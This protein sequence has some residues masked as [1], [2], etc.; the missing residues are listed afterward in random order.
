VTRSLLEELGDKY[1]CTKMLHTYLPVLHHH[2]EAR[3]LAVKQVIEIGVQTERSVCM[4]ADYFPN[5]IIYGVDIDEECKRFES[6]RVKILI[7]DQGDAA[8][9]RSLPGDVDIIIDDGSHIPK[10]VMLGVEVLFR[11]K[12]KRGG[13][14]VVEDMLL[15]TKTV[16]GTMR[17]Q[18]V[19]GKALGA[20]FTAFI[21]RIGYWPP[22]YN[23]PWSQLNEFPE[24]T[25]WW[26]A[27][28]I[29]ISFY[30]FLT[31]IMKGH[32][33]QD[34]EARYRIEHPQAAREFEREIYGREIND[35]SHL[36]SPNGSRTPR[37]RWNG[38]GA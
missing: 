12:L 28:V 4:W 16:R 10:H 37:P 34:G 14:Y 8:F 19:G 26:A 23:A 32:N 2:F 17:K 27:N 20:F 13:L 7:G 15:H 31:V 3:R 1:R 24:D 5:A 35:W 11:H 9:L 36:D 21:D 25:D 30:R 6:D 29:G 18:N 33:P 22:K 38:G